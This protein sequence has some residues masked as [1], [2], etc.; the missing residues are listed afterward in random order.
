MQSLHLILGDQLSPNIS[1]LQDCDASKDVVMLAEV[2]S[3][4]TY[5]KHHKQKLV[6]VFSAMRHFADEL[7]DSGYTVHYTT[8]AD[9]DNTGSLRGEV[10]RVAKELDTKRIVVT[11][12]SEYRVLKD[13][14]GWEE[15]LNVEVDMR[16]DTRWLCSIDEFDEWAKGRKSLRMEHFYREMRRKTGWL[17]EGLKPAGGKWNYDAQNRKSLPKSIRIPERKRFEPDSVTQEVIGLVEDRF[18]DHFGDLDSFGWAVTR[19]DALQVLDDFVE[20]Y[21]TR[22]GDFQ[23]ALKRGNPFL[24]H[25]TLSAY[26][27]IG[28]L[29]PKEACE[30]VLDAYN[31]GNAPLAA[32]EGFVRQILGWREFMRGVYWAK[33]PEYEKSNF[34][35]AD[36]HL[37]DLYWTA[38]TEL[39]CMQQA[40]ESTREHAYA[41]HIQRLMVTGNFALLAGISPSEIEEWYLAVYIDAYEWVELPNTH[42][43]ALFADGGVLSTKPYA[44]SG[45]YINR[46]SDYCSTCKFN[47]RSRTGE[48]A[49]PF[50]YLY[51]NFMIGN[52]D[53][54]RSNPRM[55][56]T[57]SNMDRISQDERSEIVQQADEFLSSIGVS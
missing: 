14:D 43:M 40:L 2:V 17:M 55:G 34:F 42:G 23:D 4:A 33:M 53:L 30:R 38:D 9:D 13:I 7:R 56:L 44:A 20:N 19:T 29:S 26:I 51:W 48:D 46:M 11:K 21:L 45:S 5:V 6:L 24:F 35:S 3:E 50:N 10:E 39:V 16:E 47:P 12:P 49:C 57:Y 25:S 1:S 27:N 37:P 28:L 15:V 54:L 32:V 18:A 52:E 22:Y 41:H 8:L 31:Q 36:G